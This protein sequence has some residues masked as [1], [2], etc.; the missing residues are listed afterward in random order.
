MIW[1]SRHTKKYLEILVTYSN[2][3]Y[4]RVMSH[5]SEEDTIISI[6]DDG[7]EEVNDDVINM[8][9]DIL[10]EDY[11]NKKISLCEMIYVGI[12][13]GEKIFKINSILKEDNIEEKIFEKLLEN[14]RDE[15][16]AFLIKQPMILK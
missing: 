1:R 10:L 4:E 8:V 9:S 15:K 3:V 5:L 16:I 14:S 2:E 7:E 13:V 11:E 12:F 6:N